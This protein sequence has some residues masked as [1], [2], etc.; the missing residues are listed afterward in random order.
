LIGSVVKKK[1]AEKTWNW[2]YTFC[3]YQFTMVCRKKKTRHDYFFFDTTVRSP[4]ATINTRQA[5]L[6]QG[7][8]RFDELT[9]RFLMKNR[10]CTTYL[11]AISEKNTILLVKN[12]KNISRKSTKNPNF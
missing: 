10:F 11:V 6:S 7:H 3:C 9:L 8:F 5:L 12:Q 2:C 4:A 1:G